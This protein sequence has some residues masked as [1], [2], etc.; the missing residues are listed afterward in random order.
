MFSIFVLFFY[1]FVKNVRFHS[2]FSIPTCA[3]LFFGGSGALF[4]KQMRVSIFGSWVVLG[5][6]SGCFWAR[7]VWADRAGPG[8]VFSIF[9][10]RALGAENGPSDFG[11]T[12]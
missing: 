5:V 9:S 4:S 12:L 10:G 1:H 8:S 3:P 2:G 11:E 6:V 7:W